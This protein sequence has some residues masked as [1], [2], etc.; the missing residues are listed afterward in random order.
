MLDFKE[1]LDRVKLPESASKE[2]FNELAEEEECICGMPLDDERRE[3]IRT[4]AKHYL[5]SEDM[6]LLNVLKAKVAEAVAGQPAAP[7]AHMDTLLEQLQVA[8]DREDYAKQEVLR[9]EQEGA[10]ENP[11]F[12]DLIKAIENQKHTVKQQRERLSLYDTPDDNPPEKTRYIP[13]LERDLKTK[14]KKLAEVANT[15]ALNLKRGFL[16]LALSR[17][18]QTA[19]TQLA[20]RV[21]NEANELIGTLMPNNDIRIDRIDKSLHLAGQRG[22]SKGETLTVA[23]AF[24]ST[25]FSRS[26]VKLPFIVD[27]PAG[28]TDLSVRREIGRLVPKLADQFIAF[29]ISS[30]REHFV[31]ALAAAAPE[32]ILY[33]TLFR[34][35]KPQLEAQA[36]QH[37]QHTE[38]HD[39]M[40]VVGK[41]F[42][43]QFQLDKEDGD[44]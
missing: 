7:A 40:C 43:N 23:Y 16:S 11:D 22:G 26:S 27:S 5:G 21:R 41:P 29:T 37:A 15:V 18:F 33:L 44:V 10:R 20:E 2:F 3:A 14:T 13:K 42:F 30:E 32:P 17:A 31:P 19:Q 25:L 24:L 39:G 38:T 9:L 4:R 34:K 36:R 12:E 1:H 8:I 35:G 6:N 28:S